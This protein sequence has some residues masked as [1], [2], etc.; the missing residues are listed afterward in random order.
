MCCRWLVSVGSCLAVLTRTAQAEGGWAPFNALPEPSS[1][2]VG[3]NEV[4]GHLYRERLQGVWGGA[5]NDVWAVGTAGW[6]IHWNGKKWANTRSGTNQSLTGIWGSGP[7]DVWAITGRSSLGSIFHWDGSAWST[8]VS[9]D[10]MPGT[11]TGI[12]GNGPKD[13]WAVGDR[14]DAALERQR[15]V[16]QLPV[17]ESAHR[18]LGQRAEDVPAVGPNVILHYDGKGE[19]SDTGHQGG[20]YAVGGSGPRDV[21][22]VNAGGGIVHGTAPTGRAILTAVPRRRSRASGATGRRTSGWAGRA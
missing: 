11:L 16:H 9:T 4:N 6:I 19:W 21:W 22:V 17:A 1:G 20:G 13:V 2:A 14:R 10:D 3:T 8:T 5:S 12:W 18:C 15:L 7:K